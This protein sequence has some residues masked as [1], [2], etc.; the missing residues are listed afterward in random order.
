MKEKKRKGAI[1][2][3]ALSFTECINL[4][5]IYIG[6]ITFSNY[7]LLTFSLHLLLWLTKLL[8]HGLAIANVQMESH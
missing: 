7:N 2:Q 4:P 8:V 6:Y 5:I 1:V 3:T